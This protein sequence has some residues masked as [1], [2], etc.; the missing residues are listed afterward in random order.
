MDFRSRLIFD[1]DGARFGLDATQVRGSVWLPEL[2]PVEEA[3]PWIVGIFSQRG[4]IV[5]V[6]DLHLRFDHPTRHYRPE[7]LPRLPASACWILR[8]T[9]PCSTVI[10]HT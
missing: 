3:P 2:T 6:A 4:R 5:P 8:R 10:L 1:L 7:D 9:K